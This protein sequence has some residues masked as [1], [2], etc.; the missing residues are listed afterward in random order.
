MKYCFQITTTEQITTAPYVPP[1]FGFGV[2]L[3][4]KFQ[5][6]TQALEHIMQLDNDLIPYDSFCID[7]SEKFDNLDEI[8]DFL[9]NKAKKKIVLTQNMGLKWNETEISAIQEILVKDKT[10]T[11]NIH[12]YTGVIDN[13]TVYY[14]DVFHPNF[15]QSLTELGLLD[16]M[17]IPF[18]GLILGDNF[19]KNENAT[20]TCKT[21]GSFL[22][23]ILISGSSIANSE[24]NGTWGSMC[25]NMVHT[26]GEGREKAHL[27]V[28]NSYG[29]EAMK[30]LREIGLGEMKIQARENE[31]FLLSTSSGW[32]SALYYGGHNGMEVPFTWIGLRESLAHTLRQ[33]VLSPFPSIP[34]CGSPSAD[35]TL[36]LR[37]Y[38]LGLLLPF[39]YNSYG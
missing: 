24:Q 32:T 21:P 26:I 38:Q 11:S 6:G 19:P 37:C 16:F 17:N 23:N 39:A 30:K 5:N 14:L 28:H 20:S 3:C 18:S 2:N 12:P 8:V 36:S 1:Y 9:I 7:G 31:S 4:P 33:F 25:P 29:L 35:D 10:N 15:T 13:Q 22:Q 27:E 34:I